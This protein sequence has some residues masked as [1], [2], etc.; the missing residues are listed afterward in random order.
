VAVYDIMTERHEISTLLQRELVTDERVFGKLT[1]GTLQQPAIT[2][3]SVHHIMKLVAG[4]PIKRPAA[5]FDP[6]EYGEGLSDVGTHVVDLVQWTAFP[7]EDLDYKRDIAVLEGKHWPVMVS[8]AEYQKVTGSDEFPASVAKHVKDGTLAHYCNN[9]VVYSLRG[10]HVQLDILW[11]WEAAPGMADSYVAVFRGDKSRVDLRKGKEENF[12]P[13]VYVV[14][15][16]AGQKAEVFA[17]LKQKIAS[18]QERWPGVGVEEGVSEAR[19]VIP[20][21]YRVGHEAHFAEVT[22]QFFTYMKSPQSVPPT[23]KAGMLAKYY[24]STRGVELGREAD[25]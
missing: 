25:Q 20:P 22:N 5:F 16:S 6:N 21:R 23:E 17:A 18:L 7:K 13:E 9:R 14:P 11:K 3:E 10:I 4:V 1:A 12:V 19:I 8:K 15:N 24:V 2:A